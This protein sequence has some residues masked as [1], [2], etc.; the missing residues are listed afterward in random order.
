MIAILMLVPYTHSSCWYRYTIVR[1]F[2]NFH[3][4]FMEMEKCRCFI[5][6]VSCQCIDIT[7]FLCHYSTKFIQL[8]TLW[9]IVSIYVSNFKYLLVFEQLIKKKFFFRITQLFE[10]A[11]NMYTLPV[12]RATVYIMGILL[13]Y[14]LR[15]YPN[16]I[17][18]PVCFFRCVKLDP[19]FRKGIVCTLR[20]KR[21]NP[22]ASLS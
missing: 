1:S 20:K 17:L 12:H 3:L 19:I 11:D 16:V 9:H 21:L 13:G 8:R 22:R 10:T 6:S 5:F 2:S 15:K 7:T 18:K 14:Y 4:D